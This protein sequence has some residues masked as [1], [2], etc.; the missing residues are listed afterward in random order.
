[1]NVGGLPTLSYTELVRAKLRAFAKRD[2]QWDGEDLIFLLRQVSG[3]LPKDQISS[4]E[5]EYF[6]DTFDWSGRDKEKAMVTEAL[7]S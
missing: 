7:I 1:M 2:G 3:K 5:A 4:E 6:I